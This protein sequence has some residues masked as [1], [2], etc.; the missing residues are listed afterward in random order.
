MTILDF[1]FVFHV[2]TCCHLLLSNVQTSCFALCGMP[3]YVHSDLGRSLT[4]HELKT[5]STCCGEVWRVV[6][7]QPIICMVTPKSSVII[8]F[9]GKRSGL[10]LKSRGLPMQNLGKLCCPML[11]KPH[12]HCCALPLTPRPMIILRFLLQVSQREVFTSL[13]RPD[14]AFLRKHVRTNKHVVLAE[15]ELLETNIR[16][17]ESKRFLSAM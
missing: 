4:S 11:H 5:Y 12:D 16:T 2:R 13:V 10:C 6:T 9:Y 17:A 15:V 3:H 1:R 14:P 8:V 7:P